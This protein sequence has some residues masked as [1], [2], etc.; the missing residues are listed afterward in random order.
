MPGIVY[1]PI[2]AYI[3]DLAP[4]ADDALREVERQGREERWPIVGPAERSLDQP[5]AWTLT[6]GVMTAD[7]TPGGRGFKVTTPC[8][9][10]SVSGTVFRV[11][12]STT[13]TALTVARGVV[14]IANGEGAQSV[15]EKSRSMARP[16]AAP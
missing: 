4:R 2:D 8:A 12:A 1:D 9:V 13:G 3:H 16:G 5:L 7:I 10:V 15:A 14:R 11:N 6:N